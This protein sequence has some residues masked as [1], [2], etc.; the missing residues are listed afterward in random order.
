LPRGLDPLTGEVQK[1]GKG[2]LYEAFSPFKTSD[3][4]FS[5]AHAVLVEYGVPMYIPSKSMDGI[6]LSATQYNRL[7]ELAT[8]DGRLADSIASY[9][10]M[11]SIQ[12][13]AERDL[14]SV[15]AMIT[16]EISNAYTKARDML[17]AEDPDLAEKVSDVQEARREYGKYKR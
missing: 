13:Q 9:G 4:K 10:K 6:E 5:P 17:V 7:V 12:S 11:P 2:N 15:Q 8:A 1:A 14:G 3:G 16:Q